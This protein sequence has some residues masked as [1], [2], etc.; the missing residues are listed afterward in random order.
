MPC[1]K[2]NSDQTLEAMHT[3]ANDILKRSP[4]RSKADSDGCEKLTD[5][6]SPKM[7]LRIGK[8]LTEPE[9]SRRSLQILQDEKEPLQNR[10][11]ALQSLS[12]LKPAAE[13]EESLLGIASRKDPLLAFPALKTLGATG[14]EK[15]FKALADLGTLPIKSME[16]QK[17]FAML[18]IGYRQ[19]LAGTEPI[20]ERLL[21]AATADTTRAR[22]ERPLKFQAMKAEEAAS[23]LRQVPEAGEELALS[24]K[25]AFQVEAQGHKFY[26]YFNI[27]L[28]NPAAWEEVVKSRQVIGQLFRKDKHA[29]AVAQQYIGLSTPT[30]EGVQLSFFRKNGELF[31][32]ANVAYDKAKKTF[33]VSN[34]KE[35]PVKAASKA[36]LRMDTSSTI[37]MNLSFIRRQKKAHPSTIDPEPVDLKSKNE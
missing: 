22:E 36:D 14:T 29:N 26:F 35:D 7:K 16:R 27:R 23:V 4:L 12:R 18:L 3:T 20:L 17:D 9:L 25:A 5:G 28:E 13:V 19:G 33:V 31:M 34:P 11:F 6:E 37:S 10:V 32:L 8:G 15:T 2:I 24:R 30:R 21:K 1:L